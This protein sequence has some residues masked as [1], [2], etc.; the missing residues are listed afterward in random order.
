MQL[1]PN[2]SC[3]NYYPLTGPITSS[4]RTQSTS[5]VSIVA[6]NNHAYLLHT[7]NH[8]C[9][10]CPLLRDEHVS[11]KYMADSILGTWQ[12]NSKW[13]WGERCQCMQP[14]P[15]TSPGLAMSSSGKWTNFQRGPQNMDTQQ[16]LVNK[17]QGL[18]LTSW[19]HAMPVS[20]SVNTNF[21]MHRPGTGRGPRE[22]GP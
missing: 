3:K 18:L 11:G 22:F 6:Q 16:H 10:Q 2:I 19:C 4:V 5:E 12:S 15:G 1:Q 21:S 9:M 17:S 7:P 14:L 13:S 20:Q 8:T